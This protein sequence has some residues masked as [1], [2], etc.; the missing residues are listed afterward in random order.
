MAL[1]HRKKI[2]RTLDLP[3]ASPAA[4]LEGTRVFVLHEY[5][6]LAMSAFTTQACS[7]TQ[8]P[9]NSS[10]PQHPPQHPPQSNGDP[11]QHHIQQQTNTEDAPSPAQEKQDP[12]VA[13]IER[14]VAMAHD[15][16]RCVPGLCRRGLT[17]LARRGGTKHDDHRDRSNAII[18][19]KHPDHR[20]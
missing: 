9:P 8:S 10:Q 7:P 13:L 17:H 12:V 16:R 14:E 20:H 15:S 18:I 6:R 19:S 1:L 4:S 11:R 3:F 5:T 2:L